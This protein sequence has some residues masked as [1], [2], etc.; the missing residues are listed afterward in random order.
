MTFGGM[1]ASVQQRPTLLLEVPKDRGLFSLMSNYWD[2]HQAQ[3]VYQQRQH[4]PDPTTDTGP[5]GR[6]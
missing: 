1:I 2:W 3:K 6:L 4:Y 5:Q